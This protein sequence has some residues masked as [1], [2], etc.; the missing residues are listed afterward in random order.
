MDGWQP[1]GQASET[2]KRKLMG[3]SQAD[4]PGKQSS[5]RLCAPVKRASLGNKQ[6]HIHGQHKE[7]E[8]GTIER[9]LICPSQKDLLGKQSSGH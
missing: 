4:I 3:N 1:E 9:T 8:W 7:T 2:S 6:V 5:E